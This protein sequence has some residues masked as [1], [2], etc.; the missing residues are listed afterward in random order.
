MKGNSSDFS[1]INVGAR[2]NCDRKNALE[3]ENPN[4]SMVIVDKNG[5]EITVYEANYTS[6]PNT[7]HCIIGFR[8]ISYSDF[9]AEYANIK[10]TSYNPA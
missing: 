8:T 1:G 5:L 10:N 4:H 7:Q 2:I 9:A 3:G 6:H